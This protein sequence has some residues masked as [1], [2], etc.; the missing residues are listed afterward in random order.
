MSIPILSKKPDKAITFVAFKNGTLRE[1]QGFSSRFS[2]ISSL[3]RG[4]Q[5]LIEQ[6]K[7]EKVES[8][9]FT[10]FLFTAQSFNEDEKMGR[11]QKLNS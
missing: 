9:E 5:L 3:G 2:H 8:E 7:G 11:C 6:V 1:Y 4:G 10:K